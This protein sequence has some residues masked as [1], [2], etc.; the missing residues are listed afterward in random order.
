MSPGA[1]EVCRRRGVRAA[2]L[3]TVP[4]LAEEAPQPFD[5]VI[6]IGNNLALL[7]TPETAASML[8]ALRTVLQPDGVVVGSCLDPYLT[9]DP[10]HLAYHES[11]RRR[12]RLAGQMRLRVRYRHLIGAWFDYLF[13]SVDELRK[14]AREAGWEVE[15]LVPPN[16]EYLAALRPAS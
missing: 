13:V 9:D 4:A 5:A 16:P 11:N 10:V 15:V 2:Y 3:G 8:D 12:G 7:G 6:M 1:V 14:I